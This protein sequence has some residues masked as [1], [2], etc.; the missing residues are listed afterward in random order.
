MLIAVDVDLTVV[1][2]LTPWLQEFQLVTGGR[3]VQN[4]D[5]NYRLEPEMQSILDELGIKDY[6]PMQFWDDPKLYDNLEPTLDSK[7]AL[8]YLNSLGHDIVFVS[9]CIAGHLESKKDFLHRHFCYSKGFI[10]TIDK[11]WVNYDVLIDDRIKHMELGHK[12]RPDSKHIMYT[13]IRQDGMSEQSDKYIK[14]INWRE[15][16]THILN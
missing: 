16:L 2:S 13:G 14:A 9:A 6:K 12:H 3:K 8:F 4:L 5:G 1:D 11:H 7:R 10:D 15:V